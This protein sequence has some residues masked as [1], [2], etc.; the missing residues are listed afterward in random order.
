MFEFIITGSKYI[1]IQF[2]YDPVSIYD[3]RKNQSRVNR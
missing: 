3:T 2:T 1:H